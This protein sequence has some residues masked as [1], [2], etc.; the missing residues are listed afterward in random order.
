MDLRHPVK[1]SSLTMR[2]VALVLCAAITGLAVPAMASAQTGERPPADRVLT[3]VDRQPRRRL[4]PDRSLPRLR[5]PRLCPS[6]TAACSTTRRGP[7]QKS[8]PGSGRRHRMKGS[9]HRRTP[10]S[11]CSTPRRRSTSASST[12][13]ARPSSSSA[14]KAAATRRSPTRT[15]FSSSSIPSAIGRMV[16]CSAPVPPASS[17][18][19]RSSAK[20]KAA[21]V[22]AAAAVVAAVAAA[23]AVEVGAAAVVAAADKP[24]DRAAGSTSTG[25]VPGRLNRRRLPAAGARSLPFRSARFAIQRAT[26][27][28]GASTF[29]GTS[30]GATRPRTGRR[31]RGST[32]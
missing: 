16:S 8:S 17:T 21:A 14:P 22:E 15:A 2:L 9:R 27:R 32:T 3:W 20:D 23:V 12:T 30:G 11:A 28:N 31:F 29:S 25:M 26:C 19:D 5:L 18:T 24:A 1:V 4:K 6:S 7:P 13:T 10:K